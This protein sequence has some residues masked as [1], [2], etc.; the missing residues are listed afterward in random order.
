MTHPMETAYLSLIYKI[1]QGETIS[2]KDWQFLKS[3]EKLQK[4]E[5]RQSKVIK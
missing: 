5:S 1:K 4:E 3:Y 2:A